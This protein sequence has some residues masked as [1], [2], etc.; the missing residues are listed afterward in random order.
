M[1]EALTSK[2]GAACASHTSFDGGVASHGTLAKSQQCLA[3]SYGQL[4]DG[5]KYAEGGSTITRWS[6]A[7]LTSTVLDQESS[8]N[9]ESPALNGS[10]VTKA[11]ERHFSE[12]TS[13]APCPTLAAVAQHQTQFYSFLPYV[14]CYP[15]YSQQAI[16]G[17]GRGEACAGN[18]EHSHASL[19]D[20]KR[21]LVQHWLKRPARLQVLATEFQNF[22]HC[23]G[24]NEYNIWY[25]RHLT[26]RYS[27]PSHLDREPALYRCNPELDAGYTAADTQPGNSEAF[28]CAFFAKGCCTKGNECR[29]KHRVPTLEDECKL[30]WSRDIFGR[31]RHRDH[32][33]DMGGAGSFNHECKTLFVGGLQIDP[34]AEDGIQNLE[35][36]L[37]ESF[38]TWGDVEAVRVIPKKLI[39]F[40]TYAYRVQAE[41]AKV[42]MAD[43]NFGKHGSLL[44]VKWAHQ[45]GNDKRKCP[46]ADHSKK[47][48]LEG[49]AGPA[50]QLRPEQEEE[51]VQQA[52]QSYC[53]AWQAYWESLCV[54][55]IPAQEKQLNQ[56]NHELAAPWTAVPPQCR[57]MD[58]RQNSCM[59]GD[60]VCPLPSEEESVGN[61]DTQ[62]LLNVLNRVEGLSTAD[63]LKAGVTGC[64]D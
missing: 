57:M 36:F 51:F 41:F 53:S 17:C 21:D 52:L 35:K 47:Q 43:Q 9:S 55:E 7:G 56:Q 63:F 8:S 62:R 5:T 45:D 13:S 27:R 11:E 46:N 54:R 23:E 28:F 61:A 38:G 2:S 39:G 33:D 48:K 1:S 58:E 32:R 50:P 29:Y 37:W 44:S 30:E 6:G 34:M 16:F 24:Q 4:A 20:S 14:N 15:Q 10:R 18:S 22:S 26:D 60:T 49:M 64:C 25:G 31:E 3:D 59:L 40:V 42:A 12:H 19:G